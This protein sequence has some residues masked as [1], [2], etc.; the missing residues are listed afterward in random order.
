MM[1]S[2]EQ[3]KKIQEATARKWE[4]RKAR[5]SAWKAEQAKKNQK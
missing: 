1:T 2:Q 3:G 4:R 5:W